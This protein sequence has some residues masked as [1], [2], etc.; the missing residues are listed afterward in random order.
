MTFY[1]CPDGVPQI[2][3]WNNY[4]T[5]TKALKFFEWNSPGLRIYSP[6]KFWILCNFSLG[7]R[8]FLIVLKAQP[9]Q[10]VYSSFQSK[11]KVSSPKYELF[12]GNGNTASFVSQMFFSTSPCANKYFFGPWKKK[13][14]KIQ[15]VRG[16][17]DEKMWFS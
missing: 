16:L 2:F 9:P 13:N 4:Y 11:G 6:H 3:C 17:L 10:I 12:F 5:S 8:H 1:F 15:H 7:M 14:K